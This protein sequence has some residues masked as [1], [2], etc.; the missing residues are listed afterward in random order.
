VIDQLAARLQPVR[1]RDQLIHGDLSG[2][3]L[4]HPR[5]APGIIDHLCNP[6]CFEQPSWWPSLL[7]V[8][9]Q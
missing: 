1:G 9:A 5:H 4:F 3:V 6:E 8:T 2:N 7:R